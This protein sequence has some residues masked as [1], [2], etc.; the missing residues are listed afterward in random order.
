MNFSVLHAVLTRQ[1]P[2]PNF[3]FTAVVCFWTVEREKCGNSFKN[4]SPEKKILWSGV[5]CV[6]L[7]ILCS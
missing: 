3:P 4:Y 6:S 7:I 5:V 1:H 2:R